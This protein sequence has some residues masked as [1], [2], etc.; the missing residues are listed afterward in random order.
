MV[1]DRENDRE[2]LLESETVTEGKFESL[3]VVD[4]F[5][6]ALELIPWSL[7]SSPGSEVTSVNMVTTRRGTQAKAEASK[8]LSNQSA[9]GQS[10]LLPQ[11]QTSA[12][13]SV[14]VPKAYD[15]PL[16]V[17]VVPSDQVFPRPNGKDGLPDRGIHH[18]CAIMVDP[19]AG[20][21]KPM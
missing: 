10:G 20:M 18:N 15:K 16:G 11:K 21:A 7:S 6:K 1:S 17:P 14:Q 12:K 2:N 8:C 5:R 13:T 19:C 9:V 4:M 3:P